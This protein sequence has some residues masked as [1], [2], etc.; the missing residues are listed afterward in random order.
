MA[1]VAWFLVRSAGTPGPGGVPGY[2]PRAVTAEVADLLGSDGRVHLPVRTSGESLE[3]SAFA[4]MMARASGVDWDAK[5]AEPPAETR[6]EDRPYVVL[7]TWAAVTAGAPLGQQTKQMLR[8]VVAQCAEKEF[9]TGPRRAGLGDRGAARR[10][11]TRRR[12]WPCRPTW[13][14]LRW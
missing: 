2:E 6:K 7:T 13:S 12:R 10:G 9:V 5:C 3:N 1:L 8:S 4:A 14:R 11:G